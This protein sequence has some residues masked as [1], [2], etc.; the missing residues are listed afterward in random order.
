MSLIRILPQDTANRIAAGE[1][2]E[3]PA[4]VVKELVENSID[5]GANRINVSVQN[6]GRRLVQVT[7]DGRGMDRDDALLC[8][9]A[10]ATS[11]IHETFDIDRISTLGFRG[12][13]LPSIAAVSQ[14]Q[15]Q[16]RRPEDVSGT[17]IVVNGGEIQDVRDCGCA[18]GTNIRVRNLFF[19]LPARRKFLRTPQTEDGHVQE[20]VLMQALAHP[21]I[22]FELH[23]NGQRVL[24]VADQLELGARV[25]M[26]LGRDLYEG[27]LPVEYSEG[28]LRITGLVARPGVTRTRRRDQRA[29]VN[30]RP[31]EARSIFAGLREAYQ[32]LVVKGRYPPVV[33][34][35]EVPADLVDVNVHPTKR[36]VRFRDG[37][38]IAG[39]VAA[40]VRRSLRGMGRGMAAPVIQTGV[41]RSE[42]ASL[43]ADG[44]SVQP[45][46]D[47]LGRLVRRQRELTG[48]A[49]P[50]PG[51]LRARSGPPGSEAAG[52][53]SQSPMSTATDGEDRQS[54]ERTGESVP[55]TGTLYQTDNDITGLRILGIFRERY[56]VGEGTAGLVVIDYR[57]AVE[58]VLFEGLLKAAKEQDGLSQPLLIPVTLELGVPDAAL[59]KQT[60][61]HFNQLGFGIEPFGGDT[62][63]V[64][65]VPVNFPQ[66]N[67][68]GMVRDMLDG[69]REGVPGTPR[70]DELRVAQVASARAARSAANPDEDSVK[71]ALTDLAKAEMPYADPNGH[72]VM[73]NL[74]FAEIERRFGKRSR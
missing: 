37:N 72:P 7:D 69:L 10:H 35:I 59:L 48:L 58:R 65:A 25:A 64:T 44:E 57:A 46:I 43:A 23:L 19:N 47:A 73:I 39:A 33:L 40:A 70:P 20:A 14:F 50:Q 54:L 24:Q 4:S 62:F 29:F 61:S 26:L 38:L 55:K 42:A 66:E 45:D 17:E 60:I 27:M 1:V 56:I 32:S 6:G 8:L 71:Q 63:L 11:K 16:T 30:G 12:E 2:V 31:A 41:P 51:T 53:F 68:A 9:E 3:R 74:P 15:L 34:Y 18:S 49:Q 67:V 52:A 22:A 28:A 36:E 21:G 13:A 5:A